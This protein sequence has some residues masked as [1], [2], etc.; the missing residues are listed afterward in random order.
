MTETR[1][2][3]AIMAI[4]VERLGEE[5][6]LDFLNQFI[7]DLSLAIAG[8]GGKSG[9]SIVAWAYARATTPQTNA[10]L[11]GPD[12]VTAIIGTGLMAVSAQSHPQP[13]RPNREQPI[14]ALQ[15]EL[16]R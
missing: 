8:A 10:P 11:N 14:E 12:G 1:R 9:L 2:L 13:H 3:A 4:D 15:L 16:K 7:T 6:F 5:R